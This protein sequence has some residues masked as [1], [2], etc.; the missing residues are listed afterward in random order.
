MPNDDKLKALLSDLGRATLRGVRKCPKCGTY[1]GTRG[2]IC[3]NRAC[4]VVFKE[5]G[6]KR[7]LSTEACKLITGTTTQVVY[8]LYSA[9][10]LTHIHH[11]IL[12]TIS[13]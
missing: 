3:K 5:G 7:K 2:L 6:E 12:P 11:R 9:L 13:V 8:S 10:W 4:D 1:N